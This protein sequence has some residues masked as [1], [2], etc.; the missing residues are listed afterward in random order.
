MTIIPG[1]AISEQTNRTATWAV[2]LMTAFLCVLSMSILYVVYRKHW[3]CADTHERYLAI[4]ILLI[5]PAPCSLLFVKKHI[6][7]ALLPFVV[8]FAYTLALF[9][10]ISL[11]SLCQ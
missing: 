3:G 7:S 9:L 8:I 5:Y 6:F 10:V 4:L 2:A 1:S 11:T